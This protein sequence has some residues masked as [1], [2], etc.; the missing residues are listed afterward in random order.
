MSSNV[1]KFL[2][3]LFKNEVLGY[4]AG[5]LITKSFIAMNLNFVHEFNEGNRSCKIFV[6]MIKLLL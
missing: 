3:F 1:L 5:I 6:V 2:D 4:N